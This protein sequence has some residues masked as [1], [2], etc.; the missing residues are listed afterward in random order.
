MKLFRDLNEDEQV[1]FRQWA[2]D[3][4]EPFTEINVAWHPI[5][6]EE[7]AKINTEN[8]IKCCVCGQII[9]IEESTGWR[10]GHN[11][12]PYGDEDNDRCC[13]KCN[14]TIVIP[15]RILEMMKNK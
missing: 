9:E 5:V 7:C 12:D 1:E 8:L 3:N 14:D 10:F 6:R 2:R 15:A 4:Y 11:A 13:N